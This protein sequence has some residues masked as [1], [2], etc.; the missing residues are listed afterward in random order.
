MMKFNQNYG[1]KDKE[2]DTS[3]LLCVLVDVYFFKLNSNFEFGKNKNHVKIT[4]SGKAL[5]QLLTM[6][7]MS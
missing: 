6:H 2:T 1:I 4:L 3:S 5:T 7:L